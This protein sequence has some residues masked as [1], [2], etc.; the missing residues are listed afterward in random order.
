[1]K[2]ICVILMSS[3]VI[4]CSSNRDFQTY[5][6]SHK[7]ESDIHIKLAKWLVMP[8]VPRENKEVIRKFTKGMK[9]AAIMYAE[10]DSGELKASF[11]EFRKSHDYDQYFAYKDGGEDILILAKE[12]DGFIRE[13]ILE[14]E[15]GDVLSIVALL[16]KMR[17]SDFKQALS[18]SEFSNL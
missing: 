8:F 10:D 7:K 2:Y 16:G 12:H 5:Y 6:K 1:M 9:K 15:D 13:I 14:V 3:L 11:D 18:D 17:L 4:S